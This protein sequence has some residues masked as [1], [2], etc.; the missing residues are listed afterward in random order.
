MLSDPKILTQVHLPAVKVGGRRLSISKHKP[1]STATETAPEVAADEEDQQ[2]TDYPRP[3][4]G[5]EQ[6]H[7]PHRNEEEVP[8][9]KD[10]K[11]H[12]DA[13]A[14]KKMEETKPTRDF[15]AGNKGFGAGGR[16]AQ[17]GGKVLG[18]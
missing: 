12:F 7:A 5:G 1:H 18:A 14:H 4:S 3:V 6:Q 2:P 9:K 16:I 15:Q 8:L 11:P 10:K 17:P 13:F